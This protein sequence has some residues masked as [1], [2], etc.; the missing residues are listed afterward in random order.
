[1]VPWV[2][3]EDVSNI[4]IYILYIY[5]CICGG[6]EGPCYC[7]AKAMDSERQTLP[8]V[9]FI[10]MTLRDFKVWW[11]WYKLMNAADTKGSKAKRTRFVGVYFQVGTDLGMRFLFYDD[12]D[13]LRS[14]IS[15]DNWT[16]KQKHT[17]IY[18][19]DICIITSI[20][21]LHCAKITYH[22]MKR[23]TYA[24]HMAGHWHC[25]HHGL[26]CTTRL[27]LTS[28]DMVLLRNPRTVNQHSQ[29][30]PLWQLCQVCWE[31]NTVRGRHVRSHDNNTPIGREKGGWSKSG[32]SMQKLE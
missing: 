2:K 25:G 16:Q 21:L 17:Y 10:W 13:Q 7:W 1:M 26:G 27:Y 9:C 31:T 24:K 4:Y 3:G 28:E 12:S 11:N 5:I 22:T 30:P 23:F 6:P 20:Q 14:C 32:K 18:I 8:L 29:P 19:Y 15:L